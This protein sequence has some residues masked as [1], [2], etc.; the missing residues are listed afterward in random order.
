M[1]NRRDV[2]G[3]SAI[4]SEKEVDVN[5]FHTMERL[6]VAEEKVRRASGLVAGL[7][8]RQHQLEILYRRAQLAGK[9]RVHAAAKAA[10]ETTSV[11][12]LT[13]D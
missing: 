2:T 7:A 9:F 8:E 5:T 4:H 3:G 10:A 1:E 12:S 11:Y 6:R 13:S